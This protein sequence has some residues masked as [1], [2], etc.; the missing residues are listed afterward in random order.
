M[1]SGVHPASPPPSVEPPLLELPLELAPPELPLLEPPLEPPLEVVP[2]ELPL[3]LVVSLSDSLPASS[4]GVALPPLLLL[5]QPLMAAARASDAALAV[6]KIRV[7]VTV[8]MKASR[9]V[10]SVR[11]CA[12]RVWTLP[13]TSIVGTPLP[14][15]FGRDPGNTSCPVGKLFFGL[16]DALTHSARGK[17]ASGP[18][19]ANG[20][21]S[22]YRGRLSP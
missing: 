4:P 10:R 2:L 17:P 14:S 7:R 18:T 12:D 13:R 3:L 20:E 8:R 19:L 22:R 15:F 21:L 6:Q 1:V 9:F 16:A 11:E 5:L